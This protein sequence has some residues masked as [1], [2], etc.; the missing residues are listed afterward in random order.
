MSFDMYLN[1]QKISI[2]HYEEDLFLFINEDDEY[3]RLMELW[4]NYY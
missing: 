4:N 1:S 2:E 3:P